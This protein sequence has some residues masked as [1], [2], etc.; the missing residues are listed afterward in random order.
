[1]WSAS[2]LYV[3]GV[4]VIYGVHL[5]KVF[6]A[7]YCGSLYLALNAYAT[8]LESNAK[9]KMLPA[10][11]ATCL[12]KKFG[13]HRTA[14]S[15]TLLVPQ[16]KVSPKS[17]GSICKESRMWVMIYFIPVCSSITTF[18]NNLPP[19]HFIS[20]MSLKEDM[21]WHSMFLQKWLLT[22]W[23]TFWTPFPKKIHFL[24][25]PASSCLSVLF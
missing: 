25:L 10:M 22:T 21:F 13:D 3:F 8:W 14:P 5:E 20:T 15:G 2:Y 6:T 11:A 4:Q 18:I 19:H 1:M 7:P 23:A 9:S 17:N 12:L 24:R 16:T